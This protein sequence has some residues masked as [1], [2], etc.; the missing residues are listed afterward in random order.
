HGGSR[1]HDEGLGLARERRPEMALDPGLPRQDRCQSKEGDGGI[2]VAPVPV[3]PGASLS[4][5]KSLL[6]KSLLGKSLL[7]KS[8]LGPVSPLSSPVP[9]S[10]VP[11]RRLQSPGSESSGARS[12]RRHRTCRQAT[13]CPRPAA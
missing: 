10:V 3:P 2:G 4:W 5:A 12:G 11:V 1:R 9:G 6:G 8:L 7:G 13:P